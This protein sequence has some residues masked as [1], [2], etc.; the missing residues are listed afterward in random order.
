MKILVVQES[1]WIAKGPHQSHHLMER[2]VQ[3]GHEVRVID[4][5]ILW[6]RNNDRHLISERKEMTATPKVIPGAEIRVIRPGII[7]LPVLEYLSLLYTHRKE[8]IRQIEEFRPDVVVG[9]GIL[10]ACLAI[11]QCRKYHIPFV[12]Y[13]IDELFRLVPQKWLQSFAKYVEQMNYRDSDLVLSINEALREYTVVMGAAPEKT[14]VIRAGIDLN[15]FSK[16]DREKKRKELGI[17]PDD[18][19][20]FFMGWLYEFSGLKEVAQA[21]MQNHDE[22]YHLKLLI[23]GEGELKEELLR[24]KNSANI[25]EKIILVGW[26]PYTQ[27]PDFLS[28]ADICIL[29]ARNNE[30]MRNIVPIKMYEYMAAGRPVIA[31][32]LPGIMKEFGEGN[33]VLY[34]RNAED[35]IQKAVAISKEGGLMRLGSAARKHVSQNEW[36]VITYEFEKTLMGAIHAN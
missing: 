12:Y 31:T 13:I 9:F 11:R 27:I 6:R 10:N 3:R 22:S 16:A 21:M 2:L 36:N 17:A 18:I 8:I 34:V 30:I 15:W 24:L 35:I 4:F 25:S 20:L 28:A 5:D 23:V 29:P 14:C 19:V 1:N 32:K 7:Q 33:G 26:Q